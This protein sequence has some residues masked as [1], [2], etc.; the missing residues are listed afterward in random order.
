MSTLVMHKT[1]Q[2]PSL[3]LNLLIRRALCVDVQSQSNANI[4]WVSLTVNVSQNCANSR[5]RIE[6]LN[7]TV[8]G[9]GAHAPFCMLVLDGETPYD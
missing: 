4:H 6:L 1:G 5:S 2:R 3:Q 8:H 7:P 9:D